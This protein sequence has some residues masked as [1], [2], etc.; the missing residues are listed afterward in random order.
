MYFVVV[1][2]EVVGFGWLLVSRQ[3]GCVGGRLN[4]VGSRG[5]FSSSGVAHLGIQQTGCALKSNNADSMTP[6]SQSETGR[7]KHCAPSFDNL[8][9]A[10][11]S[12]LLDHIQTIS[13]AA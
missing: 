13:P 1:N 9:G 12:L 3:E 7:G 5:V 8:E 10:S 4:V 6:G 11:R 2:P